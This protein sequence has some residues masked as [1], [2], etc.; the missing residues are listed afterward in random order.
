MYELSLEAQHNEV[1]FAAVY[2][3]LSGLSSFTAV[4]LAIKAIFYE[5]SQFGV[6][7]PGHLT[8]R[9]CQEVIRSSASFHPHCLGI[10]PTAG[11]SHILVGGIS[12]PEYCFLCI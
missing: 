9:G 10:I 7:R 5:D 11:L 3:L 8:G 6:I 1:T 2:A 12:L 4:Q